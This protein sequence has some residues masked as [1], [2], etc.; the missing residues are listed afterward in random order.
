M[1]RI[2]PKLAPFAALFAA[3]ALPG[4]LPAQDNAQAP[5]QASAQPSNPKLPAIVVTEAALRHM[6]DRVIATGTLRPVDEI[7]VQ[8]LVDGLAIKTINV[9]V[10]SEVKA[11]SVLASLNEDD[12][13]LQKSQ[14]QANKAK[15]EASLA[16]YKA[17]VVEAQANVDDAKRQRDRTQR[18]SQSG[19]S[20]ISQLEQAN[21]QLQVAQAR[22][23]A[24]TQAVAVGESDIEVVEAQIK[25]VDLKLARTGI[26][27]PVDG[28]VSAKNAKIGAI[29]SGAG[30]PLFTV[31]KDG[32]IELV[33]DL[34]ETDIQKVKVGQRANVTIAGS[35]APIEGKIRLVS[36][37]VDPTTRLGTVHII[38]DGHSGARAGMYASAEIIVS[39]ADAL[40]LPLSAVTSGR[41]GST[42]RRVEDNVVKQV[43]IQTGIQD[44][45]FVEI[46]SG[47]QAGDKVVAKAGAFVRDGDRIAPVTAD[48]A[49][50]ENGG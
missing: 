8:P 4:P 10:G 13:I 19:T 16:Q 18:L 43:K 41:S 25:D 47:L 27:T 5:T 9:D 7:Y 33:A 29:A 36:P 24:A 32:A 30:E 34:S 22:L 37:T 45:G 15:A 12:L 44:G 35:R 14:L 1:L 49:S 20:T 46:V 31:I 23:N 21:A 26:K 39:E 40:A 6:T 28:V 38:V 48:A 2:A 42:A 11:D 17:Q 50:A 3:A